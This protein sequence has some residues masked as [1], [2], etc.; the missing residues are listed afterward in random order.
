MHNKTFTLFTDTSC[1]VTAKGDVLQKLYWRPDT[2]L[3]A[4]TFVGDLGPLECK[5]V[6][7]TVPSTSTCD[8][9]NGELRR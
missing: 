3:Y 1:T 8:A 9:Q 5:P 7:L 4:K 2:K 6:E